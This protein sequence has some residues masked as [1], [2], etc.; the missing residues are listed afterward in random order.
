MTAKVPGTAV[1]GRPIGTSFGVS[2]SKTYM[3]TFILNNKRC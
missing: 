3:K 2:N 1:G